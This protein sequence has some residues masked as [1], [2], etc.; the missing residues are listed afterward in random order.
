MCPPGLRNRGP[1]AD[2]R[3][4]R[5]LLRRPSLLTK[6]SVLSLLVIVALGIGVGLMLQERI[7]RRAL[8][9]STKLAETM[10]T[11]GMQPILLPGDLAAGQGEDHLDA[12]DEQ[13]KLR[14]LDTLGILRLKVFNE[15]GVIV[16][17]D[18]RSIVGEAH[19]D[20]PGIRRAL[21]G[22]VESRLTH[23]TFDD[24]RGTRA[25]EV[26]V[27]LRL[28]RDGT[29][30]GVV[31]IYLPYEPVAA[32]IAED[33]RRLAL[34]L[35]VG[36]LLLYAT[37]FRIVAVASRR[38]RHQALHDD[39]TD[40]PNRTLLYDRMEVA[41]A[42]AERSGEPAALL[43]VDLDRFKEVN[44]TLG[45]DTGD[46]LLEE[47]AARLQGVVRR[48]DTLARLGGDEFAVLLRGLP[49][50][51]MAAELAGR[52]QDAIARPFT[53]DG[54]VA[55]LDASIGIAHCPEHGTDVHTL[56]QRA[57]VAMYDAKR[58]RTSIET[59]TPERDPYSAERLQLLGE[60]RSA[61]GAG[62]LVLH[63]QPK[64][65]VGSQRVVGV[66]A[67]L[68]WQHPVHGLLP[69]AEFV[70]LAER[71]GAIGDLTR[72]VLDAALAQCRA[73]RD[74]GLDLTMAVNL[75]A[76]N[77]A[78]ATLPDVVAGLL[79]LHGVPGDRLE[80]EI[81]EHTV[82][83]DPRRAMAILE[84][85]RALG[86]KLSLDDFGTGHSSLSY[87]KRLPLDEV[88][89]D[90]SFVMGM[91]DDDNDAAIVRTTIDLARNLGLEVVA[92]GVETE[93]ILR[94]LSDLSCDIAQ[95][96]YLSKAMPADELDGWLAAR[97][98]PSA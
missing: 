56:V 4:M 46:R 98:T 36:L 97:A 58:S 52:L 50:R 76:P 49:D 39:L 27:P 90:R 74:A 86:V 9:E 92:E 3:G 34:L 1:A 94:N 69:P 22:R 72:W 96:F 62:E 30:D 18:E 28:G 68:R 12:L 63:Y 25:L 84:R 38:L 81:S 77:I 66:E 15:D 26:Y 61:I 67:L 17:S 65:D 80:C 44:D 54:V 13:L 40:L 53:L 95:G 20:S 79:E 47:V 33:S 57:D 88:K 2:Q 59:Y 41:L 45:H 37:L 11:L 78:D 29:P 91:T 89:I 83:A 60:L 75:A 51:G 82:M 85:L 87:L 71:T 7:E 42:A 35:A 43:L 32:A 5:A 8:L 23:G 48:G 73:W 14:D 64:V 21:T 6:F 19:P 55:V 70:P 24:G 31:E 93:A 10:T 16:Y